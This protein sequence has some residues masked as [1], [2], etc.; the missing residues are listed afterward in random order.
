MEA[1][2]PPPGQGQVRVQDEQDTNDEGHHQQKEGVKAGLVSNIAGQLSAATRA[3]HA[4]DH[5]NETLDVAPPMHVSTTFHH[6]HPKTGSKKTHDERKNNMDNV[7]IDDRNEK[8]D[9]DDDEEL[10]LWDERNVCYHLLLLL[11]SVFWGGGWGRTF[12]RVSIFFNKK[13][14]FISSSLR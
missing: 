4:D 5:L 9:Q 11:L 7:D 6:R 10:V 14:I 1:E 2:S 12:F 8:E 13:N 3:I